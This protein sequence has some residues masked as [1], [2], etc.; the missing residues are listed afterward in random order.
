M[1]VPENEACLLRTIRTCSFI[2]AAPLAVTGE[3]RNLLRSDKAKTDSTSISPGA[4]PNSQP[5]D[6]TY[7]PA[8]GEGSR[9]WV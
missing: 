1:T 4:I 2:L 9:Y 6:G 5:L 3:V 7:N 8:I